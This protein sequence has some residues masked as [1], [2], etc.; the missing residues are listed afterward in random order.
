VLIGAALGAANNVV[1]LSATM[2][3]AKLPFPVHFHMLRHSCGYKLANDG[4][5]T[6][7]IQDWLGHVSIVHTTRYTAQSPARF[8]IS[9]GI[10]E[11]SRA[12][13]C[14]RTR[15]RLVAWPF[16]LEAPHEFDE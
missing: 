4:E 12:R 16:R 15:P 5:D 10:R 2:L 13:W 6:R 8:R 7:A 1:A 14:G 11:A 9:G 3:R